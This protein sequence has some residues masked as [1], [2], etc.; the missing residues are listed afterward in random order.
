[1]SW[2][3]IT[4]LIL[5]GCQALFAVIIL[6]LSAGVLGNVDTN[7]SRVT[8]SL[9][10]SI[11][12]I[13]YFAY[14]QIMVPYLFKNQSISSLICWL[15]FMFMVFYLAAMGAIADIFPT[16]CGWYYGSSKA[17]TTCR[18]YQAIL[19]FNLFNWLLF[20]ATFILFIGFTYVPE[21]RAHGFA[22]TFS[23]INFEF[24][25]IFS[26]YLNGFGKPLPGAKAKAE[27][28]AE[29]Q[30]E[31]QGPNGDSVFVSGEGENQGQAYETAGGYDPEA[32]IGVISS[33]ED[34]EKIHTPDG[35][36]E[37]ISNDANLGENDRPYP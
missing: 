1:M 6:G 15:E 12:N 32:N 28:Q 8:F 18:T 30:A 3:Q 21:I 19:P 13:I 20:T 9:V 26:S 22:H 37:G 29:A 2:K 23:L 5:R 33:D 17:T 35:S 10:V 27:A 11:F 14:N 31:G 4:T 24:G 7:I 34:H 25:T 16:D 36:H